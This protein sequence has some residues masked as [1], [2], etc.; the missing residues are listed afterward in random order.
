VHQLRPADLA[1]RPVLAGQAGPLRHAHR[2]ALRTNGTLRPLCAL[3]SA[4]TN[5][6]CWAGWTRR[7]RWTLRPRRR[8]AASAHYQDRKKGGNAQGSRMGDWPRCVSAASPRKAALRSNAHCE[9]SNHADPDHQHGECYGI[10]VEPI[11]S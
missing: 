5:G 9:Q 1:D 11:L 2:R 3:R 8:L 4:R 10:I 7:A 6:T